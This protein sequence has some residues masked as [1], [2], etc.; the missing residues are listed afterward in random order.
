MTPKRC[1][2]ARIRRQQ[3]GE[4]LP[5]AFMPLMGSPLPCLTVPCPICIVKSMSDQIYV[6]PRRLCSKCKGEGSIRP[7]ATVILVHEKV[8]F[9][10]GKGLN[11]TAPR[12]QRAMRSKVGKALSMSSIYNALSELSTLGAIVSDEVIGVRAKVWRPVKAEP[13]DVVLVL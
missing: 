4:D 9:V 10:H 6:C 8:L 13:L 7:S 11:A 1:S 12:V 3:S 2:H 5:L